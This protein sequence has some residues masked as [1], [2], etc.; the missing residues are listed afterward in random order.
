VTS[1]VDKTN[2]FGL[3]SSIGGDFGVESERKSTNSGSF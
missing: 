2:N 3:V 1:G